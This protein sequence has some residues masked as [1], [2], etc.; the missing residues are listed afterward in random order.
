MNLL[1]IPELPVSLDNVREMLGNDPAREKELF[2]IFIDSAEESLE[3]MR[4]SC[5]VG[6]EEIW[7]TKAHA[8]KGMSLNLGATK[9]GEACALAQQSNTAPP[10]VKEKLLADIHAEYAKVKEFLQSQ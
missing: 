3:A 6:A 1:D 4:K 8:M 2:Q 7:R 10:D 5:G 9:L